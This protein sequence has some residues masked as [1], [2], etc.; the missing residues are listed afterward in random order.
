M[1]MS[2]ERKQILSMLADGKISVDEAERLLEAV[3]EPEGDAGEGKPKGKAKFIQI[4]V[5]DGDEKVNIRVPLGLIKA[6]MKFS[7]LMP[8]NAYKKI[9]EKLSEKGIDFDLQNLKPGNIE[10]LI[11]ALGDMSVEVNGDGEKKVRIFCCE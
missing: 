8:E 4:L 3:K 11:S 1:V 5:N 2:E 9:N 6:G 10:D 7:S